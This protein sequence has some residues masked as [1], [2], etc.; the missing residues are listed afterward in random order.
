M[1]KIY[2]FCGHE[3]FQPEELVKHAVLAEK[4]GFDGVLVSEHF[5][6]WVDD[7]SSSGFAFS[8]LGAIAVSTERIELMTGVVTP[9]FR[10]H[11]AV[12]AQAAATIDRLSSGRFILGVGTG[13]AIN[14]VPLGYKYPNYKERSA[15]MTEALKIMRTLLDGKEINEE[16]EYY[17]TV[18]VKLYSPPTHKIPIYLA[19][20][21]HKSALLGAEHADGLVCSVKNIEDTLNELVKPARAKANELEKKDFGL[22]TT[23]WSVFAADS[24]EAWRALGPWRGLRAPHRNTI[25]EP[26]LLQQEADELP[27][28]EI[29][30]KYSILSTPDDYLKAYSPLIEKL[31]ASVVVIQAT[32]QNRQEELI[33]MLGEKVVQTLKSL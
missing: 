26:K 6:P 28:E 15:R 16:G 31:S 1:A 17:E 25:V 14:E 30:A 19:A 33:K 7:Q 22:V 10:Y 18:H 29:L 23:H 8:T 32:S 3:Q 27:P 4:A 21:G 2:Y 12:V 20:G 5:N 24:E 9:L 13:E 11:P